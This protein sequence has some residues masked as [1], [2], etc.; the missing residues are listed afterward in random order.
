LLID[1]QIDEAGF[2]QWGG[3]SVRSATLDE[4]SQ[5]VIDLDWRDLAQIGVIYNEH[6][7]SLNR[8]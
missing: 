4:I 2:Q 8:K 5:D 7:D 6:L 3:D 1:P